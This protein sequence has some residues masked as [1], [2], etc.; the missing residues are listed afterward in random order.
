MPTAVRLRGLLNVIALEQTVTEVVRR[1][2]SLRTVFPAVDNRPVQVISPPAPVRLLILDLTQLPD[3][4]RE[5]EARRLIA[6]EF[7]RPFDLAHGPLVRT[8]L[9]KLDDQDHI[10]LFTMHHIVSDGRFDG[11]HRARSRGT[12]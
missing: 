4:W 10:A 11:N 12:L 2:E 1:H 7:K 5:A 6:V 9:L 3:S 8:T